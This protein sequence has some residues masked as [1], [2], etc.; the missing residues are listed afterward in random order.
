VCEL[1]VRNM[2]LWVYVA[3]VR[4]ESSRGLSEVHGRR[5]GG[6]ASGR[7]KQRSAVV[8]ANMNTHEARCVVH[9][10]EGRNDENPQEHERNGCRCWRAELTL[11]SWYSRARVVS[12]WA[13]RPRYVIVIVATDLAFGGSFCSYISVMSVVNCMVCQC[14]RP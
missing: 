8:T 3:C 12:S 10:H 11:D 7:C 2:V 14:V 13:S 1:I 4:D 5:Q 6:K 9:T